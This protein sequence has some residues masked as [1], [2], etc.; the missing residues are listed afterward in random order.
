MNRLRE[1]TSNK[2]S[3]ESVL[4]LLKKSKQ[5][6][7]IWLVKV[8]NTMEDKIIVFCSSLHQG[9]ATYNRKLKPLANFINL[10]VLWIYLVA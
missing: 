6:D 2:T 10:I 8:C 9:S 3:G 1:F 5:F 4:E 7:E